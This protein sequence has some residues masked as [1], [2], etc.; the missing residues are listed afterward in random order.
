MKKKRFVLAATLAAAL[1]M[2]AGCKRQGGW[3][4]GNYAYNNYAGQNTALCVDRRNNQRLPDSYCQRGYNGGGA[5]PFLWYYLGR[6]SAIPYYGEP[7]RGGSFTRTAGA[8]YFHTTPSMNM[9]R[10]VA[11]SRGGFGSS[12]RSSFSGA[13]GG[14]GG[15]GG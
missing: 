14:F 12:A 10:S 5:N 11:I 1:A 6:S 13:R 3:D 9:T 7:V 4:D 2:T 8:T 15:V